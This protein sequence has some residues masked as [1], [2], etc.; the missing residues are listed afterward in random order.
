[1][2]LLFS[3]IPPLKYFRTDFLQKTRT[4]YTMMEKN[5]SNRSAKA[6]NTSP[7]T[8]AF[9]P[10]THHPGTDWRIQSNPKST[11]ISK[12]ITSKHPAR[13]NPQKTAIFVRTG[14]I[15]LQ[16]MATLLVSVLS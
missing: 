5:F 13:K 1:M 8:L 3:P 11:N 6:Q 12:N 16:H 7:K 15:I 4:V 14:C 9:Q 10:K 2:N